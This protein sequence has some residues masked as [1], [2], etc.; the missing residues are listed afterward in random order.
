MRVGLVGAG[1]MGGRMGAALLAAGH[2][3]TVHDVAADRVA[4]LVAEGAHAA[5]TPAEVGAASEITLLSLPGPPEVAEAVDDADGVAAGAD[6]GAVIADL[7]TVDPAT[8]ERLA[9]LVEPRGIGYVDAPVLG[10]PPACGAWTLP[11]G[12]S[13][14][15][16]AAAT[17]ALEVVAKRVV[18][19]GESGR[20]NLVKLLNNLMFGAINGITVEV[21]AACERAGL[22]PRVFYE[23]VEQSGAATVSNLLRDIG[24]KILGDDDTTAFTIDLLTKD[25]DLGV[26]ALVD[27]GAPAILSRAIATLNQLG[28]LR[29]LGHADTSALIGVYRH[30]WDGDAR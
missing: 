22:D 11:V 6:A 18:H 26:H 16:V 21:F 30:A 3:L 5:D 12:G 8:T 27:A 17:P 10:R 13:G 28:Q 1:Q 7:S 23:T 19:V 15:A 25:N 2:D 4:T 14:D 9:Q 29:G 20:G 24:P